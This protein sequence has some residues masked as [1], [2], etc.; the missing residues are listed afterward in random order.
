MS[1]TKAESLLIV[2][3]FEMTAEVVVNA[4]YGMNAV[5]VHSVLGSQKALA[6]MYELLRHMAIHET[7]P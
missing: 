7:R 5:I 2:F 3:G 1:H 6:V 4:E